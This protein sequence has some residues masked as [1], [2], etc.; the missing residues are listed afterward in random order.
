[1]FLAAKQIQSVAIFLKSEFSIIKNAGLFPN[2]H[3]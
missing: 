1:M 2:R 3:S